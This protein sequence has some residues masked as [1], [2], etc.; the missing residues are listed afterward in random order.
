MGSANFRFPLCLTTLHLAFQTL[1][2][3]LL[4]RYTN[5]IAGANTAEYA[6]LPTT[7]NESNV[8][9]KAQR[10]EHERRAKAASVEISWD[11]WRR[12]LVPPAIMFS[13][14]LILSNWV[15]CSAGLLSPGA[16]LQLTPT[17][18]PGSGV[19]LPHNR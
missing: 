5:L 16:K 10:A 18:S 1:A 6:P 12:Q 13:L 4:H 3:R 9:E 2:T 7:D 19:P 17:L 8:D 15:R 11:D 14:S